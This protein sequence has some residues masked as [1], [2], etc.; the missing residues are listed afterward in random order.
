MFNNEKKKKKKRETRIETS[1]KNV[2]YALRI[3]PVATLDLHN[4]F[5]IHTDSNQIVLYE[6]HL[7]EWNSS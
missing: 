6:S 4:P 2:N 3:G 7:C 5:C 1:W